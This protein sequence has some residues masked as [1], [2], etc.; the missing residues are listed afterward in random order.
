MR[1]GRLVG[2]DAANKECA[3]IRTDVYC[4]SMEVG[5]AGASGYIGAELLRLLAGHPDLEVAVAQGD[6][7]AGAP[8]S[9]LYPSL[10]PAYPDMVF[11]HVDGRALEGLDVV[12]VALP[13]GRSQ[14]LVAQLTNI[15]GLLVD[16]GA[17]FRLRDPGLYPLWYGFE[18]AAPELLGRF[19][20]GLPELCR[21]DIGSARLIA[22]A[23]CYATAAAISLAPLVR[24]GVLEPDVLIVDAASGTSGAGRSPSG[25]LHHPV[26]NEGLSAYGIL[27]HRHT[28]EME[29]TIGARVLFTPHLAP[30]TRGILAT[31]YGRAVDERSGQRALEV[32]A[33]AYRNDPFV[34]V[35]A[36]PASTS[37]T[38]GSNTI[39]LSAHYDQRTGYVV[40]VA[41]MDNLIKGGAGQAIQ[42][43]NL[44]LGLEETAGLPRVGMAP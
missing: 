16:L 32:L 15:D 17:D 38:Y 18:H 14:H 40:C 9:E 19:V 27:T 8:I 39:R 31:S 21:Q 23:G 29:Q 26:V 28:P 37:E 24:E 12:F 6:T 7:S 10:E 11:S 20:Y 43:A 5:I 42:A 34:L 33:E 13:P 4:H 44:A 1:L 35:G 41:A 25:T 36:R 22:A 2:G 30:M 3:Y